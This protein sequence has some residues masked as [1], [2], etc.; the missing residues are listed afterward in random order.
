MKKK[1]A[2][3]LVVPLRKALNKNPSHLSGR[4]VTNTISFIKSYIIKKNKKKMQPNFN[5]STIFESG[6]SNLQI[7]CL[8]FNA[9]FVISDSGI[10]TALLLTT[11]ATT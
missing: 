8:L 7:G 6:S 2:S 10:E 4:Q 3:L 9:L 1:S 11:A 5:N